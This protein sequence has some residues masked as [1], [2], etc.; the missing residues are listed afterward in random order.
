MTS[1]RPAVTSATATTKAG[2]SGSLSVRWA[3]ATPNNGDRKVKAD[4]RVAEYLAI[5]ANQI[6]KVMLTTKK[7]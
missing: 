2:V 7:V 5:I 3:A 1:T 4:S 6:T